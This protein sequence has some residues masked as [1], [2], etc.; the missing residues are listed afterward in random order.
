M[1]VGDVIK[2]LQEDGWQVVRVTGSHRHYKHPVK[3]GVVTVPGHSY[4]DIAIGTWKS[5]QK[6]AQLEPNR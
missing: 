6:Q 5:I 2:L 3:P 4:S 1:K